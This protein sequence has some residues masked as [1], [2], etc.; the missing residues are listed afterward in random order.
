[1]A[2]IEDGEGVM[3]N[4]TFAGT[5]RMPL[6]DVVVARITE[7]GEKEFILRSSADPAIL[8]QP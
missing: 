1:M 5:D 6:R 8:P 4:F 3:S 7:A 2:E